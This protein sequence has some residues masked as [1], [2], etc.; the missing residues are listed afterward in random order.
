MPFQAT[1]GLE[2]VAAMKL[3]RE[4]YHVILGEVFYYFTY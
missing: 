1:L 3:A 4:G 2:K